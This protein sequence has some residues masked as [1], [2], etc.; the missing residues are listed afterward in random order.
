MFVY[1]FTIGKETTLGRHADDYLQKVKKATEKPI[2]KIKGL[3]DSVE[4]PEW[5]DE[6]H[7][8][9][10]KACMDAMFVEKDG[11]YFSQSRWGGA[12]VPYQ[13][14]GLELEGPKKIPPNAGDLR[15]GIDIRVRYVF[16]VASYRR[17]NSEKDE[18]EEWKFDDPPNLTEMIFARQDGSWRIAASPHKSYAVQ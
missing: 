14:R 12:P 4:K 6:E 11:F 16:K 10:L 2:G 3:V 15:R 7:Q 1:C 18:W 13:F 17:Y 9:L 8:Q 5:E